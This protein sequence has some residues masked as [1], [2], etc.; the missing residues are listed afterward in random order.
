M[1]ELNGMSQINKNLSKKGQII[2]LAL[3]VIV[4]S[5]TMYAMTLA[6]KAHKLSIRKLNAEGYT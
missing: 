1:N 6:I 3:G 5:Y 4:F 2:G